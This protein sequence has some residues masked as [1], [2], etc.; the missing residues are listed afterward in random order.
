MLILTRPT[1]G[2]VEIDGK[3]RIHVVHAADGCVQLGFDG[4]DVALIRPDAGQPEDSVGLFPTQS[5]DG[6]ATAVVKKLA[7]TTRVE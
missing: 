1:G 7:L 5:D 4:P 2:V 3:L 6:D